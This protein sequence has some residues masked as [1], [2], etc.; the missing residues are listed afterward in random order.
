MGDIGIQYLHWEHVVEKFPH[1]AK[2]WEKG[3][4]KWADFSHDRLRQN[5]SIANSKHTAD[6]IKSTYGIESTVIFPPVTTSIDALPW[7]EKEDA[8]LCSGRIVEPKQ[9][10]RII[11][12]LKVVREKGFD[13]KLYITGGG[14]GVYNQK[15]LRRVRNLAKEN[16]DWVYLYEDLPYEDYLDF[17]ARCRYGIHYKYEPFGIS[18]AEIPKGSYL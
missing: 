7:S 15:Y 18:V 14:G 11:N 8:F 4:M 2:S 3:L 9:T 5:R 10:H 1:K 12:I 13:V 17:L 16:K 6:R